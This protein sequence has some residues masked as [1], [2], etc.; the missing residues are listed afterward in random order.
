MQSCTRVPIFLKNIASKQPYI[1]L[2]VSHPAKELIQLG[3]KTINNRGFFFPPLSCGFL[4]IVYWG[5]S[6]SSNSLTK[7]QFGIWIGSIHHYTPAKLQKSATEF[8]ATVPLRK[9][10]LI[11]PGR[12]D[13]RIADPHHHVAFE[14]VGDLAVELVEPP[15]QDEEGLSGRGHEVLSEQ[16]AAHHHPVSTAPRP[17]H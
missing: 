4:F 8:S 9:E 2:K 3:L 16:S 6:P 14:D 7:G 13:L 17:L 12:Y 5:D 11:G 15:V 10:K 1:N